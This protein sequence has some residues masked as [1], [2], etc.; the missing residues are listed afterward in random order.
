M[1]ITEQQFRRMMPA[2]GARLD[3]H[4]PYINPA[5]EQAAINT[6][7]RIAAFLAQLAH[8]S[9]EYRHMEEIWGPTEA[10]LGY[11]GAERLGNVM[12]GDG[13]RYKGRGPIQITGRANYMVC[14]QALGLDLIG[15]PELLALP[16][17]GTASACWYWNSRKLSL[18][19]D[20]AWFKAITRAINGGYNGLSDRRLYWDRN[21]ALLGLAPVDLAGEEADIKAFQRS[22]GLVA[23]GIIGPATLRALE[24]P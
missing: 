15:H 13:Y 20:R 5:L 7:E 10:Q 19:A 12:P 11:E 23:D 2:A 16:Q 1:L 24:R 17:Y 9:S 8:E 6:P 22:R 3:A 14:G 21:R 4:W 18:L